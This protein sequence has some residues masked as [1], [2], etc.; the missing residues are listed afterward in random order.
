MLQCFSTGDRDMQI[1]IK[2][3]LVALGLAFAAPLSATRLELL[4]PSNEDSRRHATALFI[5]ESDT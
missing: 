5:A 3:A 2:T 1:F 4:E